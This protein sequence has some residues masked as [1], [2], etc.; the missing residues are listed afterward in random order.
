META[1][2]PETTPATAETYTKEQMEHIVKERLA[3]DRE[4]RKDESVNKA[5]ELEA[6]KLAT[7][8][9]LKEATATIETLKGTS[10]TA[11]ETNAKVKASWQLIEKE[12]PEDKRKIIPRDYTEAQKIVYFA[13]NKELF[14]P[15]VSQVTAPITP[16]PVGITK[17]GGQEKFG[18]FASELEF[19]QRNHKAYQEAKR[20]GKI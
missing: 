10:A 15:N 12:I 18:G 9:K 13:E 19:A 17:G 4:A 16:A 6:A 7:E 11:E 5:A 2:T 20:L 8:A 1:T 3:R 14:F